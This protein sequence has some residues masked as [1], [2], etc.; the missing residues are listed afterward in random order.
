M[1]TEIQNYIAGKKASITGIGSR[2][3]YSEAPSNPTRPY[4]VFSEVI[5]N[6]N[7]DSVQEF[8]DIKV[9]FDVYAQSLATVQ[10]AQDSLKTIF[11][12]VAISTANYSSIR[13]KRNFHFNRKE[14]QDTWHGVAEFTFQVSKN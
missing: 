3:Y 5:D 11:N 13:A 6:D 14:E 8:Q 2:L 4:V 7:F 12:L 10:G 1:T 9:Q